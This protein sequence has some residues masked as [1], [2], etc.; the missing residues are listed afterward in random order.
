MSEQRYS[1]VAVALHWAIALLI[2][3]Q[4]A[5]GLYMHN[6]PNS[7]AA[8]FDLYQLHKS[9]G[10]SI[11]ALTLVR[12][13][14]RLVH[15][16]PPLPNT[17]P[18]WQVLTARATHWVFYFLMLATPLVGLAIVS[19]SPKDIPTEWFGLIGVPHLGFLDP[20]ADPAATEHQF[21]ELHEKLSYAILGLLALHVAAAMKHGFI[22]RDGVLR[23]MAPGIAAIS[24]AAGV[25][26]AL[27]IGI[28]AYFGGKPGP[29]EIVRTPEISASVA[30]EEVPQATAPIDTEE[31]VEEILSGDPA[32]APDG[33]E[34]VDVA[35]NEAPAT[36]R[37]TANTLCDGDKKLPI[38]WRIDNAASRLRFIGSQNGQSFEG[39]FG[40]FKTEIAFDDQFLDQSWLRVTVQTSS[41]ATGDQLIDSTLPGGEW[42]GVKEFPTATFTA[43]DIQRTGDGH[44]EAAGT[45]AIKDAAHDI[46]LPF[47]L[48][49]NDGVTTATG[50]V[51]LIRTNFDLGTAPSW[52]D[53]EGV[54]LEA[55]IEFSVN[56][57]RLN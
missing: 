3:G 19:V 42:F 51:D 47:E 12:L 44:Y 8:K 2:L 33:T 25:F 18:G 14:W 41:A 22:N 15:K 39:V 30:T 52:L 23:S 17:M 48:V 40:A 45:L 20:G 4:I 35:T 28:A 9:F 34:N 21:I 27:A 24:G 49:V 11:F 32:P 31:P 50:G 55:R 53:D 29:I 1:T 57:S 5:G 7:A 26:I 56:A 13:G 36:P 54:A 37:L 6:L 38:N 43:C 46:T 10:L 16:P